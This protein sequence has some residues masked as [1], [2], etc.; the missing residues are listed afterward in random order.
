MDNPARLLSDEYKTGKTITLKRNFKTTPRMK[1]A[2]SCRNKTSECHKFIKRTVTLWLWA[3]L[4][5][6]IE[7]TMNSEGKGEPTREKRNLQYGTADLKVDF[8]SKFEGAPP[9]GDQCYHLWDTT[10]KSVLQFSTDSDATRKAVEGSGVLGSLFHSEEQDGLLDLLHSI[11]GRVHI[12]HVSINAPNQYPNVENMLR[13]CA[14]LCPYSV[15]IAYLL[16]L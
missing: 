10:V 5:H 16:E 7:E 8:S 3:D 13:R 6:L 14:R 9:G 4:N 11:R 2:A 12:W 1:E 15:I